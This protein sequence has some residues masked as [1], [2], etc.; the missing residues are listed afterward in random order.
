MFGS[1]TLSPVPTP[2]I[3]DEPVEFILV[4]REGIAI[5]QVRGCKTYVI[6]RGKGFCI[7]GVALDLVS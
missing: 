2:E 3:R 6:W 7:F 1:E 5:G 4:T